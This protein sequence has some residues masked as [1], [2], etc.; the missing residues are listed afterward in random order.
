M[1]GDVGRGERIGDRI[2]QER[3]VVVDKR[4][5]HEAAIGPFAQRFDGD[6]G[7]ACQASIGGAAHEEGG[8]G[9]RGFI[10]TFPLARQCA[11]R[12]RR[13]QRLT[14]ARINFFGLRV[15]QRRHSP[16]S[17]QRIYCRFNR[18]EERL[19]AAMRLPGLGSPYMPPPR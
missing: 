14:N 19:D 2:D 8:G 16:T 5:P 17:H 13:F 3:H 4:D 15:S 10:E 9:Q 6:G 7:L 12:Q 11:T 1:D 18:T